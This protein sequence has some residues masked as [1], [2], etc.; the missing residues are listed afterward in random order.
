MSRNGLAGEQEEQAKWD[1][2]A[3]DIRNNF[4]SLSQE[5]RLNWAQVA[6]NVRN[7]PVAPAAVPEA[8]ST[9]ISADPKD[10]P[11]PV[12][13]KFFQQ[14]YMSKCSTLDEGDNVPAKMQDPFV[15][16]LERLREADA[17]QDGSLASAAAPAASDATSGPRTWDELVE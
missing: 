14:Q 4:G 7:R 3:N 2:V 5:G 11:A 13:L 8:P 10:W 16:E 12:G 9:T 17:D 6:K 1:Q 15:Q